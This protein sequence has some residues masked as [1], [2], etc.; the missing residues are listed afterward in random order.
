MKYPE[1]ACELSALLIQDQREVKA[2]ARLGLSTGDSQDY[3]EQK[4]TTQR[5]VAKRMRRA[6]EILREVHLP[7]LSNIGRDGC[8]ALSVLALH[9]SLGDLEI[10]LR[11]F[12]RC[13]DLNKEDCAYDLIPAMRDWL[14]IHQG[15]PQEFGAQWLFDQDNYPFLPTVARFTTYGELNA[16][17]AAYGREPLHWPK[18]LVMSDDEQPWLKRPIAEAVM[19]M[20]T[21]D[22][23]ERVISKR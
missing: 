4:L 23:L 20:P 18:S 17:R 14:L 11:A 12:E 13:F 6:R 15:Q 16:R 21:T 9:A 5:L 10:V 3:A 1:L 22:E 19:R 7:L 8:L 2:L